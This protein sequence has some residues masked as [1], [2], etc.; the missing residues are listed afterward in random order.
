MMCWKE[1]PTRSPN[2]KI[3]MLAVLLSQWADQTSGINIEL[4]PQYPE[5]GQNVTLTI[6]GVNGTIHI[7][8]WYKG[9][10]PHPHN[11]I[12]TYIPSIDPPQIKGN[13]FFSRTSILQ[14][15]S[16]QII[17]LTKSDQGK[18]T[19]KVQSEKEQQ[20]TV[21][22]PVYDKWY[23]R[24]ANGSD[25]CNGRVEIKVN[26]TLGAVCNDFW[27]MNNAGVVCKELECGVALHIPEEALYGQGDGEVWVTDVNCT[28]VESHL[29]HCQHRSFGR[30][31]CHHIGDASVVCSGPCENPTAKCTAITVGVICLTIFG[32]ILI[33]CASFLLF[34][35]CI[36]PKRQQHNV[37]KTRLRGLSSGSGN[38]FELYGNVL[39]ITKASTL[40]GVK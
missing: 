26:N 36:S 27:D 20:V 25:R 3:C 14:N 22:L 1:I 13:Q 24:L 17:G 28:G 16:L 4:N 38:S 40:K 6:T 34:K 29:Q 30:Q 7:S 10:D 12:V 23:L 37:Q 32:I 21:Y 15:V 2:L 9:S 8:T 33:I 18:Y 35:R 31:Q 11:Q 39:N 19:V 5:F